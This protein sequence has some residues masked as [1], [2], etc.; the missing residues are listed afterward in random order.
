[1][2]TSIVPLGLF[3]H[4]N[5]Q[6]LTGVTPDNLVFLELAKVRDMC[7]ELGR[8]FITTDTTRKHLLTVTLF[9]PDETLPE[10]LGED[11]V[12]LQL[13]L[14]EVP[15]CCAPCLYPSSQQPIPFLFSQDERA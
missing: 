5:V 1:M 11:A 13:V 7:K 8:P 10:W 2:E 4:V 9:C 14:S 6:F 12:E 3:F 15:S